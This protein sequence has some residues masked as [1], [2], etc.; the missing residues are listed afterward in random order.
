VWVAIQAEGVAHERR[1]RAPGDRDMVVRWSEQ[2]ALDLA[3][4]H[5]EG[6]PLPDADRVVH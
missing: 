1:I 5:L 3:R 4:R 2:A 6:L